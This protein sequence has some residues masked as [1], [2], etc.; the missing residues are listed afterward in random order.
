MEN[1]LPSPDNVWDF[2]DLTWALRNTDTATGPE[3]STAV[4]WGHQVRP[5][6]KKIRHI[7]LLLDPDQKIAKESMQKAL[8]NQLEKTGKDAETIAADYMRELWKHAVSVLERTLDKYIL[9][10]TKR[11]IILTVP[12]V[13]SDKAKHATL[14]AAEKAGM[15]DQINMISEPQAAA[16]FA[17]QAIQPNRMR[18]GDHFVLCDAGG[19]TVDLISYEI[20]QMSPLRLREAAKGMYG[21]IDLMWSD[22]HKMSSLLIIHCGRHGRLVRRV[23]GQWTLRRAHQ[24]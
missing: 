21:Q 10:N 12:A 15:G 5:E 2:D 11:Q 18:K 1:A 3:Q 22:D 20:E 23:S 9:K 7:K 24:E 19:G 16:V 4:R 8:E 14:K 13:W 6:E 17:F